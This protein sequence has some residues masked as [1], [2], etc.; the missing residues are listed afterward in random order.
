MNCIR[1]I[2]KALTVILSIIQV[3]IVPIFRR[4]L[5]CHTKCDNSFYRISTS[6]D[7]L[8]V[9][10]KTEPLKAQKLEMPVYP[11]ITM[12]FKNSIN[13]QT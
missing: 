12:F 2:L 11:F 8:L 5:K 6:I 7:I 1:A 10:A 4:V 3:V 13:S 9:P